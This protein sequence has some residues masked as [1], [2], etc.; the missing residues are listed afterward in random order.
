MDFE[1]I[2]CNIR[3]A[4]WNRNGANIGTLLA[5]LPV[6]ERNK[7]LNPP[8]VKNPKWRRYKHGKH[9]IL[10]DPPILFESLFSGPEIFDQMLKGGAN[11]F[12]QNQQGWNIIHYLVVASYNIPNVEAQAVNIYNRLKNDIA[13][14]DLQCLLHTEDF[15]GLRP[16]EMTVHLGCFAM[17]DAIFNTEHVYLVRMERKGFCHVLEYDISEYESHGCNSRRHKS[18]VFL[19]ARVDKK[20]LKDDNSVQTIVKGPINDWVSAK[21]KCNIPFV[22]FWAFLRILVAVSFYMVISVNISWAALV[23]AVIHPEQAEN[24]TDPESEEGDDVRNETS[25]ENDSSTCHL[26]DWYGSL[27]N[28]GFT[29]LSLLYM[30]IYAIISIVYDMC[31]G[32]I[33]IFQ[34]WGR[35]RTVFGKSKHLVAS[36]TYYRLCQFSFSF[37]S[38]AWTASYM[39]QPKHILTDIGLI[40][41]I[42]FSTWSILYFIQILPFVGKFVNSIQEML[43]VMLQFILVYVIILIPFPHAFQVL[44]RGESECDSIPDFE[45]AAM[46]SYSTFRIMLNMVDLTSYTGEGVR[47]AYALHV[48]FVFFVAILLVNFFIA[49]MS[50]SVGEVVDAGEAIMMIQRLSVVSVVEWRLSKPFACFYILLQRIFFNFHH[51]MIY[52]RHHR[53]ITT[54]P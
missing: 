9:C 43:A 39:M 12:L 51:K 54:L 19:L 17:F 35:F 2:K 30:M 23:E 27:E 45:T 6:D 16:L 8:C 4:V 21:V 11:L 31:E 44:L 26:V 47:V 1:Y 41:T 20:I 13:M 18:P 38:I 53:L 29:L 10:D 22:V 36:T 33:S 5:Q 49:L 40:L 25:T 42:F 7:F 50:S 32:L 34:N 28:L 3:Q 14:A 46:G 52:L 24:A 15:E 37:L 48:I